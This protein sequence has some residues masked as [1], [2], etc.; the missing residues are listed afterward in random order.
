MFEKEGKIFPNYFDPLVTWTNLDIKTYY[1]P[2]I[3]DLDDEVHV[4]ITDKSIQSLVYGIQNMDYNIIKENDKF[5]HSIKYPLY[6]CDYTCYKLVIRN[7][8]KIREDKLNKI[9][10]EN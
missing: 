4:Y 3:V 5:K 8:N 10:N 7:L 1:S 9:L 2:N 6:D